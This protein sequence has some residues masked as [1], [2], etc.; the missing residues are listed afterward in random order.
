LSGVG[1]S[2]T[3]VDQWLADA[4]ARNVSGE[5]HYHAPEGV[6]VVR[7][8][9]L[10]DATD[11][12]LHA[13]VSG[14]HRDRG[15]IPVDRPV[16]VH[17]LLRGT[18]YEFETVV[19]PPPAARA[20]RR[21]GGSDGILLR[22]PT[23]LRESQRR[24]HLRVSV[25]GLEP[26][27]VTIVPAHPDH[28]EACAIDASIVAARMVNISASGVGVLVAERG[29]AGVEKDPYFLSF[30]LPGVEDAF[31][32]LSELR[33]ARYVDAGKAWRVGFAYRRWSGRSYPCD[34]YAITR[35]ITEQ[36]RR[37]LRRRR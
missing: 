3:A 34:Q 24:G 32:M 13:D 26:I 29:F 21:V 5:V 18:R 8:I 11:T 33:Y 7:R 28:L 31:D 37:L 4:C 9:R 10:R 6:V 36:E 1:T 16:T 27:E 15:D 22:K 12:H 2:I 25:T 14:L 35:F 19:D 20:G 23:A 17:V 30:R